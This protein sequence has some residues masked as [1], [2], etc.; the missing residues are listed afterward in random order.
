MHNGAEASDNQVPV[1]DLSDLYASCDDPQIAL[2]MQEFAA[3]TAAFAATWKGKLDKP[4]LSL[5]QLREALE[6]YVKLN[7]VAYRVESYA[8]LL[9]ASDTSNQQYRALVQKC[10]ES[11]SQ[12]CAEWVFF[13]L[14]IAKISD[15]KW[16]AIKAEPSLAQYCHYLEQARIQ[17]KYCLSEAEERILEETASCRGR[18]F[19]R[20]FTELVSRLK[21]PFK[22]AQGQVS[23]L[24]QSELL[25]LSYD[26]ER[27][28]RR[29]AAEVLSQVL[30]D[31]AHPIAF[32]YNT[33]ILEKITMD[34]LRGFSRP[35]QAR[36][37]ADEVP[38]E[39]ADTVVS[40]VAENFPLVA[41]YYNLKRQ[42]LG[43]DKLWH[44]DRYA[45]IIAAKPSVPFAQARAIVEKAFGDF[46]PRY[47]ELVKPF[48]EKNWIDARLSPAKRSGAFCAGITPEL[49]PYVLMNY[50][51]KARD[52]MTLAHELGHGIHDCLASGQNL[53][54]YHP[55]LPLAETASTFAEL[56]VFEKLYNDMADTSSRLG[57]VCEKLEDTFATVFRQVAM[58]RFEQRVFTT[59]Q[60]QGELSLEAISDIWQ[61]C[62]QEMFGKSLELG[63]DHRIT[64]L[65]VPHFVH[66]P[67][68]VYAY[69]FGELLVLSL[70]ARYQ[71]EGESFRQGY[72]ELLQAGGSD[73]PKQLLAKLDIDI[74]DRA[75]WQGGCDLVAE[76]IARAEV[77]A[78]QY[79]EENGDT[80]EPLPPS[81]QDPG[82]GEGDDDGWDGAE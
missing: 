15:E 50:T 29:Q 44:Y 55:V 36:H 5:I 78:R 69:A 9:F 19:G 10:G 35:D 76:R 82:W 40:V 74:C 24:S 39:A 71:K 62:L 21:Y 81:D 1:W 11:I 8:S 70:Y 48:F 34:R 12:A 64:W 59:R 17:A 51:G 47:A 52:V 68:Y 45:P 26:S 61:E 23:M 32:S 65:Y 22:D 43:L 58:Y 14:E 60:E 28:V 66:T 53:L 46:S 27:D 73:G 16:E 77:L 75:F 4:E 18:A 2:D 56:L 72:I 79:V 41:R 49:H 7:L 54:N 6:S 37:L 13:D 33:I 31:N 67:F 63:E 38:D 20:L 57:L 80:W 25:A 42:L 3:G 30:T